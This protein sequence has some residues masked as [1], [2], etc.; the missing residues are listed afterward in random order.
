MPPMLAPIVAPLAEPPR[1]GS[2]A[3][4]PTL[5]RLVAEV[6]EERE[7]GFAFNPENCGVS[8]TE[9][10]DACVAGGTR[11]IP[12]NPDTVEAWPFTA[13]AGDRCAPFELGRDW[14][15][16]ARRQLAASLSFQVAGELWG[17]AEAQEQSAPN[18]YLASIDSDVLTAGPTSATDALAVLEYALGQCLHG[19]RGYIHASR[20][21]ATYWSQLGLLRREG[22]QIL[23]YLDTVVIADAGYDGSGP[24]GQAAVDGSQWAYATSTPIVRLGPERLIPDSDIAAALNRSTN[25]VEYRAERRAAVSWDG[26]CHLAAELDLG[27]AD[28]GGAGS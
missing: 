7:V 3:L 6:G 8:G 4:L 20:H 23:T 9:G 13:W 25:T 27:W 19:A 24:Y 26:C 12:D 21:A 1:P 15:G 5:G 28:I 14:Q 11:T 22:N 2:G 17:G 10:G 18:R 16:R